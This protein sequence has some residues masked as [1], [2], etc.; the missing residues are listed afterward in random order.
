MTNYFHSQ[1]QRSNVSRVSA[2][3]TYLN[4]YGSFLEETSVSGVSR[5]AVN[6][7]AKEGEGWSCQRCR[8]CIVPQAT[9]EPWTY[10]RRFPEEI[11]R[12]GGPT[13]RR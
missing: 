10:L 8:D 12:I 13:A 3:G 11:T 2:N 5:N 4:R 6:A 1:F 9:V 7:H